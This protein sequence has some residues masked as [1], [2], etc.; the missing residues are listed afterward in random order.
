M[1]PHG[2]WNSPGKNTGVGSVSLLQ[3]IFTT[4]DWTQVT[5]LAGRFFTSWATREALNTQVKFWT[6]LSTVMTIH[7][8]PQKEV[9][10]R[11]SFT[12]L[13]ECQRQLKSRI[14]T[15]KM[16]IGRITLKLSASLLYILASWGHICK[17]SLKKKK[18]RCYL[19]DSYPSPTLPLDFCI[20]KSKF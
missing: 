13:C 1:W 7:I 4:R 17:K 15:F 9:N 2:P 6:W 11:F 8:C 14:F 16:V 5:R 19:L 18:K 3:G 10:K 20:D 12:V